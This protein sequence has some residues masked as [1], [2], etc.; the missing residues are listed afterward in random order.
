MKTGSPPPAVSPPDANA[1]V[2]WPARRTG[3]VEQLFPQAAADLVTVQE[4]TTIYEAV[5][6]FGP[7]SDMLVVCGEDG[8]LTGVLTKSD[9]MAQFTLPRLQV[10]A[11]LRPVS[12]IMSRDVVRCGPGDRLGAVWETMHAGALRNVPI[13]ADDL[14]P[15]GVVS[16]RHALTLMLEEAEGEDV[17][18]RDYIMGVGYR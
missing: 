2:N 17:M 9:V 16:A 7:G 18:L 8:R 14:R 4:S 13:T 1:Y 11:H 10:S 6:R 3:L 5:S 12:T 15:I